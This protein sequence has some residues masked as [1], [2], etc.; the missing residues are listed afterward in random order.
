MRRV[1]VEHDVALRLIEQRE[2]S[3]GA[4]SCPISLKIPVQSVIKKKKSL[5]SPL[6]TLNKNRAKALLVSSSRN[7]KQK[8]RNS[9]RCSLTPNIVLA[10][11]RPGLEFVAEMF[12]LSTQNS[13]KFNVCNV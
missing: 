7:Q 9:V 11:K 5:K 2:N 10:A 6:Y 13:S 4:E 1:A 3:G 12:P 8:Q